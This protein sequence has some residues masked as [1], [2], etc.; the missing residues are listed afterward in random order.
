MFLVCFWGVCR[1]GE[2]GVRF[3]F[4]LVGSIFGRLVIVGSCRVG[5]K[6]FVEFS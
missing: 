6:F 1:C 5:L 3:W 4:C 2:V